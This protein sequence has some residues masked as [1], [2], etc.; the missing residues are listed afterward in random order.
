MT[1]DA[2]TPH[3]SDLRRPFGGYPY[4]LEPL[5][6]PP[7]VSPANGHGAP[8]GAVPAGGVP[9]GAA[10]TE[11]PRPDGGVLLRLWQEGNRLPPADESGC[12]RELY[13]FRWVT[14]HQVSF[15]IWRLMALA[16]QG[17]RSEQ[18]P[19][20]TLS[21][22]AQYVRGY[23]A[24]LLYSSSCP[25]Q[26]YADWIR[27]SMQLQHRSFSGGW[28]PDYAPVRHLFRSRR[29]STAPTAGA[30]EL[31]QAVTLY[32]KT[33][34]GVAARLVPQ[35][36]SL[37]QQARASG[38]VHGAPGADGTEAAQLG[39]LYDT[40]FV[41]LRAPVPHEAVIAQLLRR[42]DAVARDVA[43]NGLHR[44]GAEGEEETSAELRSEPVLRLQR[45]ILHELDNLAQVA[46]GTEDAAGARRPA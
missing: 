29:A 43:A 41:T 32:R 15:V 21:A 30:A 9:A 28:A 26:A 24:M 27:P 7:P 8:G 42:L 6:L 3:V 2:A 25:R 39:M 40:Y 38:G 20:A 23:A 33:H 18:L 10:P 35:G 5:V 16:D 12:A 19:D 17:P 14:G 36:R 46:T 4:G 45:D 34:A 1:P 44:P 31:R 22:L 13:W 37:L 11:G